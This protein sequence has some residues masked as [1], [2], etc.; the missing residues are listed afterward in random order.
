MATVFTYGSLSAGAAHLRGVR[1]VPDMIIERCLALPVSQTASHIEAGRDAVILA[2]R[3]WNMTAA[4]DSA[5]FS[6]YRNTPTAPVRF[7]E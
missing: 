6:T 1:I 2:E 3:D 4:M 7:E 5:S